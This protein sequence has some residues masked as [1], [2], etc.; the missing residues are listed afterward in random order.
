MSR[1]IDA[2]ELIKKLNNGFDWIKDTLSG[3]FQ[4]GALANLTDTINTISNKQ[5]VP[6]ADVNPVIRG[7]WKE[8]KDGLLV[9]SVCDEEA[10]T[11]EV[12][13]YDYDY[14]ENLIECGYHLE[15]V[16]T[17]FCPH[18]GARLQGENL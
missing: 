7:E 3:D 9:C 8:N 16:K 11:V 17:N 13:D 1:Y 6:T 18:C 12:T 2:D 10:T 15:S 5:L 14:D 4:S